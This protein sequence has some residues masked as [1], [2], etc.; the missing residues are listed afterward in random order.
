MKNLPFLKMHWIW[1]DFIILNQ[2]DLD[3]LDIK[4]EKDFIQKICNRNFWIWSDGIVI[5]DVKQNKNFKYEM[6]NPD[7]TKAEMCWNGIRCYM[8][9]LF[10]KSIIKTNFL[11]VETWVWVLKL[12]K[13]WD[14]IIVNMWAPT[15]IKN[16]NIKKNTFW[17]S[18]NLISIDKDFEISPIS[19]WNPHAV[20]FLN[21]ENLESFDLN[22]YWKDIESNTY[23]FPEKTNVE[24]IELVSRKEI[25]M[26]VF[27]R[28]AWETL[29]C[30]TGACASVV[31]GILR[32]LLEKDIFIKVNLKWWKLSIKWTWNE[33][34][35]VIMKWEAES[36]FEGKYYI[37]N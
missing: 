17:K 16:I 32:W 2:K 35:S 21:S 14:D 33:K 34:D 12:E 6:Y 1:N 31:A 5:V 28:W 27:E 10:N 25:N 36:V 26:R 9:Y 20:V 37:D 23:I 11:D 3:N 8:K 18:F 22:K 30:G 7:W 29:A 13:S 19:M 15:K 4:L 24:F